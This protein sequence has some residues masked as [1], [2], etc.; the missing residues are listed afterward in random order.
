MLVEQ[1]LGQTF[2]ETAVVDAVEWEGVAENGRPV[3]YLD[4]V[5]SASEEEEHWPG[6]AAQSIRRIIHDYGSTHGVTVSLLVS[7]S[8]EPKYRRGQ[9]S[10]PGPIEPPDTALRLTTTDAVT[11]API[12]AARR[13]ISSQ[14]PGDC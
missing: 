5:V 13:L 2:G 3:L 8:S 9:P 14:P 7:R 6:E 4:L 12:S 10:Y 11:A 1:L